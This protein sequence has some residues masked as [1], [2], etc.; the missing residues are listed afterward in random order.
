MPAVSLTATVFA[1][2]LGFGLGAL[3]YGPLFGARW[4]TEVG[5][6]AE[7]IKKDFSPAKT[8][9]ATFVL[10]LVAAY[11]FGLYV[12]Q[13]PGLSFSI[14]TGAGAGLCWVATALATNYLFER[15]SLAL[16]GINGGYHAVR[17]ALIGL[18]FG[19]LG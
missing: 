17:F 7:Q 2:V 10:G 5:L 14:V 19:L 6:T 18:A 15:R 16:I 11:A 8:Y 13:N 9:G 4:M 1:T 12:G 3:W